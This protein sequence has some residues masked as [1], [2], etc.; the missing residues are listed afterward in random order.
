MHHE[1]PCPHLPHLH[2]P[3]ARD[4]SGYRVYRAVPD[5]DR[6]AGYLRQMQDNTTF[7][8]NFW[9]DV[10]GLGRLVDIMVSGDAATSLEMELLEQNIG[11]EL[12]IPDVQKLMEMEAAGPGHRD[13]PSPLHAMT[14]DS[15]LS[16]IHI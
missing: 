14:W 11:F 5:T 6:H 12:M 8:Y 10:E 16:L 4:Y 2:F 15:Y 9:T 3:S 1:A 13:E 7:S